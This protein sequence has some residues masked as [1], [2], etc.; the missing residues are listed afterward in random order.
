MPHT[1]TEVGGA[2]VYYEVHGDGP[3]LVLLPG[4]GGNHAVWWQ[5]IAHFRDRYKVIP[6]DWPGCGLSRSDA[7]QFDI[8]QWPDAV[9]AALDHAG[10]EKAVLV[11]QALGGM[12]ALLF[13]VQHPERVAGLVLTSSI[14]R[15]SDEDFRALW[16]AD[17]HVADRR[18]EGQRLPHGPDVAKGILFR[19]LHGF[20]QARPSGL[21]NGNIVNHRGDQGASV[22]Q[23]RELIAGGVPVWFLWPEFDASQQASTY[24]RLEELLPQARFEMIPDAPHAFYW[25][26]PEVFNAAVDRALKAIH[27]EGAPETPAR[28]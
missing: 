4:A 2:A 11:A 23:V 18:P 17:R 14:A 6:V 5:Q 12:P 21:G 20:N 28:P 3:A 19:A 15:I 9:L 16:L 26:M 25:E 24:R 27:A 22:T 8:L 7:G 1:T 13:A 10:V